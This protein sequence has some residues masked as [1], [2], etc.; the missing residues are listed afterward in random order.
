M[1]K[2]HPDLSK[3]RSCQIL[4]HTAKNLLTK[5]FIV[6]TINYKFAFILT[7]RQKIVNSCRFKVMGLP[8]SI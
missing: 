8:I 4:V 6:I 5:I 7:E 2:E 1:L 3:Q